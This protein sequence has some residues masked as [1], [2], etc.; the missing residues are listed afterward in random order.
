MKHLLFFL[1]F[2]LICCN[3]HAQLTTVTGGNFGVSASAGMVLNQPQGS[4]WGYGVGLTTSFFEILF[5]E[6]AFSHTTSNFGV[7]SL[8]QEYTNQSN[9][10]GLGLNDKIP[11]FSVA[12][13]KSKHQEC[14]YL[15]L[16][17]LVDYQY[18]LR[19][20]SRSN[21]DLAKTN[22][23]GLNLG[24]GI[25]PS[26]SGSDKSRVAWTFFYDVFYHL[27]LNKV[28]Q[29]TLNSQIQQN[30]LYFRFTFLHYK[31]S[32]MLGGGSKKKAYNRKY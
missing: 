18:K 5:P 10:L 22:E 8:N 12:M 3:N 17:L 14:W 23:S 26:Y 19:L 2:L 25:R 28:D 31:T 1:V 20:G 30:G 32:D 6:V 9:F 11:L 16:K 15:N 29:P 7:D 4:G 13:G 24:L 27:D 21:F